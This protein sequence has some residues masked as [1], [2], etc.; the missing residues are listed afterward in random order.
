MVC[1]IE[2][3]LEYIHVA[4]THFCMFGTDWQVQSALIKQNLCIGAQEE[5]Y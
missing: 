4:C 2:A 5:V 1:K 3:Q